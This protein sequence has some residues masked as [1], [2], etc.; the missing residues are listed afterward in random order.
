MTSKEKILY[1][2]T[3]PLISALIPALFGW[4][5]LATLN[6]WIP[7][8]ECPGKPIKLTITSPV[9]GLSLRVSNYGSNSELLSP[10]IVK[11]SHPISEDWH[12]GLLS[13]GNKSSQYTLIFRRPNT[14]LS[15]TEYVWNN[16]KAVPEHDSNSVEIRAVLVDDYRRVGEYFSSVQQVIESD[17]VFSVSAPITVNI[18]K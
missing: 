15:L 18:E 14:K 10:F 8:E 1:W 6:D 3:I 11:S 13:K 9:N 16:L 17:G 5:T 7:E 4:Q 12:I 2:I